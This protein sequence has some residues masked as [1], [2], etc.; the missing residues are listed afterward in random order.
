MNIKYFP[1]HV[2]NL[3][4]HLM[5]IMTW[6]QTKNTC[7][8]INRTTRDDRKCSNMITDTKELPTLPDPCFGLPLSSSTRLES[9]QEQLNLTDGCIL[10]QFADDGFIT[11]D[12]FLSAETVSL[13]NQ[14]L[15][16]VLRGE[17]DSGTPPDKRPNFSSENRTKKGKKP[18]ALGGPSKRTLQVINIWKSDQSF[19][20]V[21]RSP[22]LARLVSRLGGW[23][24]ARVAN[25]QVWAKPPGAAP[26]TFHRDSPYF[27]FNPPDVITVW[28]AL[29]DMH[30]E[31]G[32][33]EYVK[34]SHTWGDARTGSAQLFFDSADSRNLV[35]AAAKNEGFTDPEA[36]LEVV[37]VNASAGGGSI[38]NGR[39]WHGSGAN[40]S[41]IKP[42]RGLGIHFIP[43][44][45]EFRVSSERSL[46]AMWQ[47]HKQE[48]TNSLPDNIFPP[49]WL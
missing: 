9:Q 26:I 40:T 32:P 28:I 30:K 49:T 18:P 36:E 48:G 43:A 16:L 29:D 39:T 25:D 6:S 3:K 23:K 22:S 7:S 15:E 27:D 35:N 5:C 17:F 44:E 24:G 1:K 13:L 20:S 2:L 46:G 10:K 21:V 41:A 19:A 42:R 45:A 31:I 8:A 12:A 34:G 11:L 37:M 38:H 14:R 4:Q 33:L 47:P